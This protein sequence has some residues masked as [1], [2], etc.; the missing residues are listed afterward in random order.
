MFYTTSLH[1][2]LNDG[3]SDSITVTVSNVSV[4]L[5]YCSSS[6]VCILNREFTV[7]NREDA[8]KVRGGLCDGL[9]QWSFSVN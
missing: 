8:I 4:C 6:Y 1:V 9:S 2:N 3:V 7:H 5:K